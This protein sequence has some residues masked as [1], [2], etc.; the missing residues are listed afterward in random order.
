MLKYFRQHTNDAS[1]SWHN[2]SPKTSILFNK[3]IEKLFGPPI[4]S[5]KMLEDFHK[6]I[7]CSVQNQYEEALFHM[8]NYIY[9]KYKISNLTLSGGCAQ[10]SLA[11]G[12]IIKN[13][14]VI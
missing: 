11:N 2:T 9:D 3:N 6:N 5:V 7:A 14:L 4:K 8:L 13:T 12:K 10:N 1:C